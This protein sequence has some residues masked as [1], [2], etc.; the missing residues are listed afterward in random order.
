MIGCG[1]GV[2]AANLG[3]REE[4]CEFFLDKLSAEAFVMDAG[5]ATF[6]TR[7]R[8]G[9]AGA[10]SMAAELVF[11]GV[12]NERQETFLAESLPAALI[13]DSK[14]SGAAAV[15]KDKALLVV[16]ERLLNRGNKF[17]ADDAATGEA[18]AVFKVDN[19]DRSSLIALNSELVE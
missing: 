10:T 13:A 15:V 16:I 8:N 4:L 5:V 3:A 12:E 7:G 9:V 6:W 19:R 1:I 2:E 14:R 11:V 17:V 18:S